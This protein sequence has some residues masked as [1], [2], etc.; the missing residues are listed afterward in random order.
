[1]HTNRKPDEH[2]NLACAPQL[3][4]HESRYENPQLDFLI[5]RSG[6]LSRKLLEKAEVLL[7]HMRAHERPERRSD[8]PV[9]LLLVDPVLDKRFQAI[10]PS[11]IESRRH[12]VEGHE[13]R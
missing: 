2:A 7:S 5:R 12:H 4:D 3:G 6:L 9:G 13:Q 11:L 8:T 1:D 10:V